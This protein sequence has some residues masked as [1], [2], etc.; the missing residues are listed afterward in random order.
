MWPVGQLF[1]TAKQVETALTTCVFRQKTL[2]FSR[3]HG[4]KKN[5]NPLCQV[6]GTCYWDAVKKACKEPN[7]G[8]LERLLSY[9]KLDISWCGSDQY[10]S[11]LEHAGKRMILCLYLN[12]PQTGFGDCLKKSS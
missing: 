7:H 11:I 5:T 9:Q 10:D 4:E 8:P 1:D 6:L 3:S 2:V 12:I